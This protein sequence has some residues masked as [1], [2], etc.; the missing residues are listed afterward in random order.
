MFAYANATGAVD[1]NRKAKTIGCTIVGCTC[2]C[3]RQ[4]E[5]KEILF[6]SLIPKNP[7]ELSPMSKF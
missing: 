2:R 5:E 7:K 1:T 4:Q 3:G 6:G